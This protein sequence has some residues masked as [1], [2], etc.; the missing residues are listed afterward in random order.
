MVDTNLM[1]ACAYLRPS[2]LEQTKNILQFV[3][4][5]LISIEK[6]YCKIS[7]KFVNK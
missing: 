6:N 3:V 5:Y 2:H 7:G 4:K 1:R